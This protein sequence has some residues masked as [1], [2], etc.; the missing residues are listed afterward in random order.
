MSEL[1]EKLETD[2]AMRERAGKILSSIMCLVSVA[3]LF[4]VG[5]ISWGMAS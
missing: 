1:I 5:Y 3:A 2:P 4:M